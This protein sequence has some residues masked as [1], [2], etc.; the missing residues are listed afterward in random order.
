MIA[1]IELA[2]GLVMHLAPDVL[3][4]EGA[5]WTCSP[6]FRVKGDHFFVCLDADSGRWLPL[7]TRDGPGRMKIPSIARKGFG[8]WT[9][10]TAHYHPAQVWIASRR[11]IVKAAVAA[12]DQSTPGQRNRILS[13]CLP[14]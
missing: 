12:N 11:A 3:E 6:S 13:D 4:A 14:A 1:D 10:S 9:A 8:K 2:R 7:Y 5:S